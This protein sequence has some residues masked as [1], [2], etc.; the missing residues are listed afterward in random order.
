MKLSKVVFTHPTAVFGETVSVLT[1]EP[2]GYATQVD[3]IEVAPLGLLVTK[4]D[5]VAW[6]PHSK[7]EGGQ[8]VAEPKGGKK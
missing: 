4:G 6:V 3:S 5:T 2:S 8:V 7:A 1:V